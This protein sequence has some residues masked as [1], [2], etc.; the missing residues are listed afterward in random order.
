MKEDKVL[1]LRVQGL[2]LVCKVQIPPRGS[3]NFGSSHLVSSLA[4]PPQDHGAER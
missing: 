4:L 2:S 1:L 3:P